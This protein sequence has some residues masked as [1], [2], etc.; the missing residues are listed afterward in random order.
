MAGV[1]D[2]VY[3]DP[4]D[5]AWVVC[6]FKTD[7]VEGPDEIAERAARYATQGAAYT[8]ALQSALD[9]PTPPRFELWFL[10]AGVVEIL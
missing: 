6:D 9:L 1:I 3:R 4:D 5:G 7:R 8:R 10:H 2:L